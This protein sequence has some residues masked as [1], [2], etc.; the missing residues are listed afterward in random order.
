MRLVLARV[1]WWKLHRRMG[2]APTI[3]CPINPLRRADRG[4]VRFAIR[5]CGMTAVQTIALLRT[6]IR[7]ML[8]AQ[9]K[10]KCAIEDATRMICAAIAA[11]RL[12]AFGRLGSWRERTVAGEHKRVP[13]SFFANP[14]VTILQTGWATY[15]RDAPVGEWVNWCGPDWGDLRFKCEEVMKGLPDINS[16]APPAYR[17][18]TNVGFSQSTWAGDV[19]TQI[20]AKKAR[21]QFRQRRLDRFRQRQARVLEWI[22]FSDIADWCAREH[23]IIAIDQQL[24]A[25]AYRELGEAILR[26]EFDLNGRTRVLHLN[27]VTPLAR[28]TKDVFATI[29]FGDPGRREWLKWCWAPADLAMHWFAR[30]RVPLPEHLFPPATRTGDGSPDEARRA[31]APHRQH[32]APIGT[33]YK[34]KDAQLVTEIASLLQSGAAR[35]RW[36]AALAVSGKAMGIGNAESKAKRL[37]L[38]YSETFSA[39]RD[40]ED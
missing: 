23:G 19:E 24:E 27:P 32:S 21:R 34:H 25:A 6:D 37:L 8:A 2:H 10:H 30:K 28:M 29:P 12:T 22:K 9:A 35:N 38:R 40:G 4:E 31:T 13:P 36:D 3:G 20:K 11:E 39:E 5:N 18:Y 7:N 1:R 26:G 14:H 33:S 16:E 15:G 17:G